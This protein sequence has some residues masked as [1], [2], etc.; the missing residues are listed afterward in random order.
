MGSKTYSWMENMELKHVVVI[1]LQK[2]SLAD[3]RRCRQNNAYKYILNISFLEVKWS[4]LTW[5][6][7]SGELGNEAYRKVE[8]ALLNQGMP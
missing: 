5:R 7:S 6:L 8:R 4:E 2:K 3:R 1:K